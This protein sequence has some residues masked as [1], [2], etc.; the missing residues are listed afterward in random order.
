[1]VYIG[2]HGDETHNVTPATGKGNHGAERRMDQSRNHGAGDDFD[3]IEFL[4]HN[5]APPVVIGRR[6]AER[7]SAAR[8]RGSH[9]GIYGESA[10]VP[11]MHGQLIGIGDR[12]RITAKK[13]RQ[14]VSRGHSPANA[15][16]VRAYA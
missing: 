15:L 9:I 6:W 5:V 2:A 3:K 7:D 14:R 12:G 8:K 4:R 1:M 11:R 10:L 16:C 13:T